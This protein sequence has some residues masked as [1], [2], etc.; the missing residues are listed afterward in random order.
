LFDINHLFNTSWLYDLP[1]GGR[2]LRSSFAPLN[3]VIGGWYLSGIFTAQSGDPLT[4]TEGPGVWGGSLFL[5]F[6]SGAL[7]KVDPA[8]L[9]NSINRGIPGSKNIGGSGNPATGGWGLNLFKAPA[10]VFSNFRRVNIS[11]DGRAG[12]AN[13]LRG[14]P[15]WNLD[16]SIGKKTSITEK[17]NVVFSADFFNVLNHVDFANPGL[18]LTAPATFG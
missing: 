7:S 5:G 10:S 15:R 1:F 11:T 13:P 9:G 18:S 17:V 12:I 2:H 8:T 3:K 14:L 16:T 4:V 6:N